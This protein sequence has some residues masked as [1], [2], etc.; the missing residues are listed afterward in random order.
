MPRSSPYRTIGK[1]PV[2]R[3]S[4]GAGFVIAFVISPF[5]GPI[6]GIDPAFILGII[7]PWFLFPGLGFLIAAPFAHYLKITETGFTARGSDGSVA[8]NWQQ[9]GLFYVD[10]RGLVVS[11]PFRS[12]HTIRVPKMRYHAPFLATVLNTARENAVGPFITPET[13]HV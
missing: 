1:R 9:V 6:V 2:W 8:F 10:E 7:G 11:K 4:V 13:A 12:N 3:A 5:I